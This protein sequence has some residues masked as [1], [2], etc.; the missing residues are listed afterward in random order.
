MRHFIL[1]SMMASLIAFLNLNGAYAEESKTILG[2]FLKDKGIELEVSGTMDLYSKYIWR[3]MRLDDDYV[4]QPGLAISGYG[5]EVSVWSSFDLDQDDALNSDEVDTS[6]TY[7]HD[8]KDLALFG[9]NLDTISVTVGHIYYDFPGAGT[10]SKETVLGLAYDTLL[11][12]SVTWYHDYSQ[13][14]QGGGKGDYV[15]LDLSHS[16][17]VIKE[18]GITF[19]LATHAGYNRKLFINGEG[20][21]WGISAGLTLPLTKNLTLSPNVNYSVPLGDVEDEND[22]NYEDEFYWSVATAYTF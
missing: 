11:S 2:D 17:D 22:G 5:F 13:E 20:G 3:G 21:D 9:H 14:A 1:N 19:D 12:P 4:I 6:I 18:Y 7:T 15:V 16:F 10:F 8:F